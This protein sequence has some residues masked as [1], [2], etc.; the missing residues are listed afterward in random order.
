MADKSFDNAGTYVFGVGTK[1]LSHF[2]YT[3]CMPS[4]PRIVI[5][6]AY[7]SLL[8]ILNRSSAFSGLRIIYSVAYCCVVMKLLVHCFFYD[9]DWF[10]TA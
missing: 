8:R 5:T 6:E 9:S 3:A 7:S 1:A 4:C 2:I 10:V